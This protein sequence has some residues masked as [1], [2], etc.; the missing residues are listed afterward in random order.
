MTSPW[1]NR[2]VSLF[3]SF[4]SKNACSSQPSHH[5]WLVALRIDL[6][7]LT[8]KLNAK[9]VR[10]AAEQGAQKAQMKLTQ[11][12]ML[13]FRTGVERFNFRVAGVAM[14][15]G[16]VLVCREDEDE[17]VMLPGGRVEFGEQSRVALAREV[18]EELRCTGEVG[19]LLFSAENFFERS[20]E[21]FHEIGIYYALNLPATFAF[22]SGVCLTTRDEG[23]DLHFS[24]IKAE[25]AELSAVNLL[26]AWIRSRF[27]ALPAV[28]EHVVVDER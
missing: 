10:P 19:R 3:R 11:R 8:V 13:S 27:T 17:F 25:A 12:T 23:H 21:Q 16:H 6:A 22:H 5:C 7:H 20:G 18:D 24:W 4:A 2:C 9:P 15:D 28:S 1:A 26:P 14:R